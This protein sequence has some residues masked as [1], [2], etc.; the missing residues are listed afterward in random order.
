MKIEKIIENVQKAVE[1][2]NVSP[3]NLILAV[4]KLLELAHKHGLDNEARAALS[5]CGITLDIDEEV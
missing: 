1:N 2:M 5:D 3:D 4:V